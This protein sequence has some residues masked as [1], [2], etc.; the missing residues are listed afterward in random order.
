M[1]SKFTF[2][3]VTTD[4][5]NAT[6]ITNTIAVVLFSTLVWMQL[7]HWPLPGI[8]SHSFELQLHSSFTLSGW[9]SMNFNEQTPIELM[10]SAGVWVSDKATDSL[11]AAT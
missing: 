9:H 6:M 1:H 7:C 11:S 2:S 8:N 5:V 3:G 10:V 4:P